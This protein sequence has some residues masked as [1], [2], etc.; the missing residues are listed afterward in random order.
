MNKELFDYANKQ[1]RL[2]DYETAL[3]FFDQCL[4]DEQDPLEPGETGLLYH[5]IGNCLVRLKNPGEA[6]QAYTQAA[7]DPA[8]DSKG[9]VECNLGMAYATLRDYDHAISCFQKSIAEPDNAS[10]YKAYMGL[11][12]ALMKLG[13]SA[14]A[15]VAFREA[16]LD[17]NNSDPTKA[18]LNLGVCFMALQRPQDA[19]V[20]YEN[21]LPFK[22]SPNTKNKLYASLGQ[23]Y[24]ACGEMDKAVDAF[25]K[26]IADKPYFLSDSASV[27]YQSA[28]AALAKGKNSS[29][30]TA[31]SPSFTSQMTQALPIADMSGLD[32]SSD[33]T[34]VLSSDDYDQRV[35]SMY[36]EMYAQNDFPGYI[37]AYEDGGDHFFNA[38]E[39]EIEQWSKGLAKKDRKRRNIGLK[40]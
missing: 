15:G 29:G 31:A 40:V 19:V 11:G 36:E 25:E 38:S 12:N 8:Y 35:G 33:G 39:E 23:A 22:M 28:V 21:A 37:G 1:Y 26:A 18:L 13:K 3:A 7:A 24:V 17:V 2:K 10:P 14:E 4:Q 20:S 27:D 34:A 16:A 5:Q 9:T 30:Q 6:I 32:I